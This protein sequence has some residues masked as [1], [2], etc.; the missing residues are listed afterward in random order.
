RRLE[1]EI[2]LYASARR[3]I[4]EALKLI[5]I[6]PSVKDIA[7]IILSDSE[8]D[9]LSC[10]RY[11]EKF[12]GGERNDAILSID[13]RKFDLIK[14]AFKIT[15]DEIEAVGG[16]RSSEETIKYLIIEH[17]ALLNIQK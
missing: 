1:M 5:G 9:L 10:S 17:M 7:V 15:E 2:L 6:K 12:F 3:Q 14:N 4:E 13:S 16:S 8:E 11:V